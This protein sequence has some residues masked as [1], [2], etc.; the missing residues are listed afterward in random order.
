MKRTKT[1]SVTY[2][3]FE[4]G[5]YVVPTSTRCPLMR[6]GTP[7][8]FKV[9]DCMEPLFAEERCIVYVEGHK[10]GVDAAYVREATKEELV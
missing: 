2:N 6:E 1:F 9:I 5:T 3:Y 10:F 7:P 8:L 4:P